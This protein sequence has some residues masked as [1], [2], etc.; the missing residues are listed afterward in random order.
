VTLLSGIV[1]RTE[2]GSSPGITV[3]SFS[4]S[5]EPHANTIVKAVIDEYPRPDV[6]WESLNGQKVTLLLSSGGAFGAASIFTQEATL[7]RGSRGG[8]AYLPKGKRS[9]GFVLQPDRVL[10]YV[11]GYNGVEA[12]RAKVAAVRAK[13]PVLAPLT[14]E[15]LEQLPEEGRV[16]TLAVFGTFR[17]DDTTH[18]ALWLIHSYDSENDIAEGV[19]FVP[20][21]VGVSEYGSQYGKHLL[22]FGGEVVGFT[23]VSFADALAWTDRDHDDVIADVVRATR[24]EAA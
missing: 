16:C 2:P 22:G 24:K 23:P 1:E 11:P 5:G 19:L 13:F 14:Q 8:V 17:L 21:N 15:R 3:T 6:D 20:P 7:F 4:L 12:L 18:K 9:K 10:D